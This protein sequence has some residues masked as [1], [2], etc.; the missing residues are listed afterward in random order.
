MNHKIYLHCTGT[1]ASTCCS[2]NILI[3][4]AQSLTNADILG[5]ENVNLV[6]EKSGNFTFN[7]LWEPCTY[8]YMIFHIDEKLF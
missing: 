6:R 2:V 7:N 3:V 4:Y 8:K 5:Q 1:F